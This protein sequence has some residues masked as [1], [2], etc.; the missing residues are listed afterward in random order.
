M[1][2]LAS[3]FRHCP[4][5]AAP[6]ASTN[7]REFRC[8]TC[9]FRYFHNVASAVAALLVHDGHLLLTRRAHAPAAGTLDLPGG[10][11]DPHETLEQALVRELGEELG[12]TLD[13]GTPRYLFSLPNVYPYAEV[14][15][16]TSDSFFAIELSTRPAVTAQDDVSAIEWLPFAAIDVQDIGLASARLAVAKFLAGVLA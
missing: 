4:A 7:P 3:P 2:E 14:T 8:G 16:A 12:L 11:V 9:G 6:S 5:C 1:T 10:F 15:Y 13:T